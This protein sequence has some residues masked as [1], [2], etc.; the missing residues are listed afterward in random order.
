MLEGT[1]A[2]WY[3]A[4]LETEGL[5]VRASSASLHCV[6]EQDTF[7]LALSTGSTLDDPSQYNRTSVDWDVL[8]Q[9]K[10]TY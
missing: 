6:L 10:Q 7:I 1:V 8:N 5:R 3:G 4:L 9:I 2:Q